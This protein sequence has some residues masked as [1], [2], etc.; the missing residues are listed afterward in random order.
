MGVLVK[1]TPLQE[2]IGDYADLPILADTEVYQGSV[3]GIGSTGY[4]R[5]F[6]LGDRF[7][8]HTFH[9]ESNA[10]GSSGDKRV[11]T[12]RGTY[13][14]E[15]NLANVAIS[16]AENRSPV[17]VQ[18]S[19]TYSLKSGQMAGHV[20]AYRSSGIALVLFDTELKTHV[21]AQTIAIGDF[22]DNTDATGYVDLDIDIPAGA[23]VR[24]WQADV[25]TGF[26][27]DTTAVIQVGES[28]NLDRFSSKVDNSV[29][30][31]GVVGAVAPSVTG[32]PAY[33]ASDTTVRV[34]V[35]GGA[36]FGSIAAGELDLKIIFDPLMRI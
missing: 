2:R 34:T 30:A 10:G 12:R 16:D 23:I 17:Y 35:T 26:T 28:G 3:I 8:G 4:A 9:G 20:V 31:A 1:D 15:I 33:C 32:D 22:T 24:G 5:G 29:L 27:G 36:D 11:R 21:Y 19:G 18:D 13:Y 7:A 6:V 25:N 14:L